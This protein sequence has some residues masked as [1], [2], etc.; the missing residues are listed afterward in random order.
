MAHWESV[1]DGFIWILLNH[2]RL[3]ELNGNQLKISSR[4]VRRT[5]A[6]LLQNDL[7]IA[8][9]KE[10][11]VYLADTPDNRTKF[12]TQE[13]VLAQFKLLTPGQQQQIIGQRN[14]APAKYVKDM[15]HVHSAFKA[16][17]KTKITNWRLTKTERLQA[18]NQIGPNGQYQI[19]VLMRFVTRAEYE[20]K[21]T[22]ATADLSALPEDEAR[23][24]YY[25]NQEE[26][27]E[28]VNDD[29]IYG[30][31]M[32][33]RYMDP[34]LKD[35]NDG[36]DVVDIEEQA[37]SMSLDINE[38]AL[39]N[40]NNGAVGTLNENSNDRRDSLMSYSDV[41]MH[42][43]AIGNLL[44]ENGDGAANDDEPI[45]NLLNG[46]DENKGGIDD[47]MIVDAGA[48]ADASNNKEASVKDQAAKPKVATRKRKIINITYK[49]SKYGGGGA[50]NGLAKKKRKM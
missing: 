37:R 6:E 33:F 32:F 49:N 7:F 50:K 27:D 39:V 16:C 25:E 2:Y 1:N 48:A 30:S 28:K 20:A 18:K 45:G 35:I 12:V 21:Q 8:W 15:L 17:F 24:N 34:A 4:Q 10:N 23:R 43:G 13:E 3:F 29:Y 26:A 14:Y 42:N 40:G 38:D 11:F 46:N 31:D 47:L 44:N 36:N 19:N 41:A 5:K 22:L 9:F